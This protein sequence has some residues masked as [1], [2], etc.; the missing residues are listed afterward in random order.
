MKNNLVPENYNSQDLVNMWRE[1]IDWDKRRVG[2][3]NFLINQF[4]KYNVKKIFDAS[5]GDGCDSIYLLKQSYVVISNEI[6]Q[7]FL[8]KAL[9]NAKEEKVELK[10]TTLDWRNL[11][12]ELS[13]E[14]FDAVVLLGNS[15]T[16]LFSKQDQLKALSQFKRIL[17]KGGILVID[18]RNYQYILDNKD[19][20]LNGEFYY[21]AKYVYCGDRVH[22]KP[23]EIS[24]DEVRF[25]Y[26]DERTC[27][28]GYLTM[29]PFKRGELLKLIQESSFQ[30]IEQ[31][32][33]YQSTYNDSADFYQ[34]LAL[35]K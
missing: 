25:E 9:E 16:Y 2:E 14:S 32:S 35:K 10:I 4:Q 6:D 24:D 23:I 13:E 15:L 28:K 1:F 33:D 3:N 31:F 34:Y 19:K 12:T 22:G 29:Y 20:I 21:S 7:T 11:D 26:L 17:K 27:N 5:L 8:N 30:E 18:E